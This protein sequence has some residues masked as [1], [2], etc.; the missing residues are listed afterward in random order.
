MLDQQTKRRIDRCRDILVGKI[1]DPK[2]QVEQITIAL[3]YKFMDDMDS[4]SI[5]MGGEASYYVDSYQKYSWTNIFSP[6][7]G[8]E[9]MLA[10]YAE[11]MTVMGQNPHLPQLFRDIFK[12]AYL[13][14]R[15]PETL[16]LFLNSINEFKYDHSEKLGDAF[17][18]LL[19]V[20]GSQGDAG[21][22]RT[23]RH[24]IDFIVK[25]IDPKKNETILDPACGT[26]GFLISSYKHILN[27]NTN[28]RLGDGLTPDEKVR[29]TNNL[30]GYDI[31]PDMVRLSLVNL[32]LHGF[33][34]PK[35]YEYDS[36]SSQD[37]W[38][39][40]YDVVLANPPFMTP[41]G[42][43][44]PH[45]R[46]G[47]SSNRAEVLFVDYIMEHLTPKG[48]AGIVVPEGIIF[49]SGKAYKSLRRMMVEKYLVGVI[50]LPSGVFNPYSGVK[51]SILVLDRELSQKTDKIFFAKVENDGYDLGAQRREIEKNDL[52]IFTNEISDYLS[53]LRN[54]QEVETTRLKFVS[55]EDI[56]NSN[57]VGLS[58]D[59]YGKDNYKNT[60]SSFPRVKLGSLVDLQSGARDK[61]GALSSGI[62]SIGGE[63]I[64]PDGNIRFD[65]MKYISDSFYQTMK[66]GHLNINDVLM[67]KDGAT[68]GKI[69]FYR[70]GFDKCSVNEHVYI[71][72]SGVE[73]IPTLLF[74][75]LRSSSFQKIL[76]PYIK[77]IIG[78]VSS[79]IK[80]IEIPL[81]PIEVQE[82]I[83]RELEQYQKIIDGAKQVV[84]NYKPVIDIDPS[85][86]MKE[87]GEVCEVNPKKSEIS[88]LNEKTI[89]SFV[90]MSDVNENQISFTPTQTK[91]IEEV[92]T[93]YTYFRDDDVLIAKVTPCFEN[94]KGGI[95]RNLVNGIG[96]GSSEYYVIR[97]NENILATWIYCFLMSDDFRKRGL[98]SMTGTG[99]LKRV[100]KDVLEKFIIPISPI[101]VQEEIVRELEQQQAIIKG[102]RQLIEIYT[103]KIQD[104]I[105]KIWGN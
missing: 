72:R 8:G 84:D 44:R 61:G 76:Q 6:R 94:G 77:G 74:H 39:E 85:W 65:K 89:V 25:I 80:E 101:E 63:Q 103:Q 26:S 51:T 30:N 49:Q 9:E 13:P 95:C 7:I 105:N 31:S 57:D 60:L 22:F 24:I 29:L 102:N 97:P 38:N 3:I 28:K 14:Y 70:G 100:P 73:I 43:I 23:P 53:G 37:R 46:F 48:R 98:S 68:T 4:Q 50:S 2:S 93:G 34:N 64:S 59:K 47:I 5:E 58:Y 35:V 56:S 27:T 66:K 15:D 45:K 16:R 32:F 41:T 19:S 18:Y 90:P 36:L 20:L 104:R 99:G 75:M 33:T 87:L 92:Y 71:L 67:V 69:G 81:P 21:Q 12:N 55:K 86:E 42:G 62:P 10:L 88:N 40:Y 96:F 78:G 1:T 52:P 79:E 91:L 17:E 82:E 83:V 54:G 11:G